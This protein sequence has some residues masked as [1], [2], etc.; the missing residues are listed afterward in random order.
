MVLITALLGTTLLAA[1]EQ[2]PD[3][4][5]APP[6]GPPKKVASTTAPDMTNVVYGSDKKFNVID[7]WKAKSDKPTPLVIFIHGGGF[8]GGDKDKILTQLPLDEF[9]KA[10]VSCA[11]IDYRRLQS[12]PG[13]RQII[14]P[15]L[16]LDCARAVQFLRTKAKDWNLDPTRFACAGGSA[17]AGMSL[18]IGFHEDLADPKS[19]DP[20]ARQSTC[21]TCV[22]VFNAQTAYDPRWIKKNLPGRAYQTPNIWQLV[23]IN[24]PKFGSPEESFDELFKT[25]SPEKAKLMEDCSPINHLTKEAPPVF[26][27]YLGQPLKPRKN[28]SDD[29]HQIGFALRLKEKMDAL[30]VEC[31][32]SAGWPANPETTGP[33]KT[34]LEFVLRQFGM[35]KSDTPPKEEPQKGEGKASAGVADDAKSLLT[36]PGKLLFSEDLRENPYDRDKKNKTTRG[37]WQSG[38]GRWEIKDGVLVGAEKAE[39][40]H[41]AMLTKQGLRFHNAAVQVAFRLDGAR[42][43]TLDANSA[44]IGRILAVTVTSTSLKLQRSVG[45]GDKMEVLDTVK[46]K[47]EPGTWHVLLLE[48]QGNEVAAS[49]DGKDVALGAG[50][51]IDVDKTSVQFRVG[52]ESAAFKDLRVWETTPSDTWEATKTKLLQSRN[53]NK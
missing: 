5:K 41:G 43:F 23:G 48:M 20:V 52:G 7:L 37:A 40:K 12:N 51:G 2:N 27:H 24:S 28:E 21:L 18:W 4:K 33:D 16:F 31:V 29:I 19:D 30:K 13:P 32:I 1:Q 38:L 10:G 46:L 45:G 6:K 53:A 39:Q 14:Y 34:D 8:G 44:A 26:L 17:G 11:S 36:K 3:A 25:I 50:E 22:A 42:A 49:I 47:L 9:L 15:T 35:K